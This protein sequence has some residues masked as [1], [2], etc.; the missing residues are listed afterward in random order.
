ME[1]GVGV[2]SPEFL[3]K[4]IERLKTA[5]D[6]ANALMDRQVT[7]RDEA[8]AALEEARRENA[9]LKRELER[10]GGGGDAGVDPALEQELRDRIAALESERDALAA[11]P[12]PPPAAADDDE[13]HQRV[14]SLQG[15]LDASRRELHNARA[16]A[17]AARRDAEAAHAQR[18]ETVAGQ[19]PRGQSDGDLPVPGPFVSPEVIRNALDNDNFVLFCQPVFSLQ[20]ER[21]TQYELLLR[22]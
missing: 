15:E 14:V 11:A 9:E 2:N 22:L 17:D 3:Q 7:E 13:L 8:R 10:G 20:A 16:E 21:I 4:K 12:P 1:A 18:R 6:E 5:L 19:A